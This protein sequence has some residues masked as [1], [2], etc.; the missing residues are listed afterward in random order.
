[1]KQLAAGLAALLAMSVS[2]AP[3]PRPFDPTL[4]RAFQ[5]PLARSDTIKQHKNLLRDVG[6]DRLKSVVDDVA[7]VDGLIDAHPNALVALAASSDRMMWQLKLTTDRS[8]EPA[9]G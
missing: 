7:H 4:D 6:G 1:M 9:A 3:S 8:K 5:L 2:A